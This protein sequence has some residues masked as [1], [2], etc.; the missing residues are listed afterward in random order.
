MLSLNTRARFHAPRTPS[1][2]HAFSRSP[3][4]GVLIAFS[5]TAL[6]ACSDSTT[7]RDTTYD[8]PT[9]T[10]TASAVAVVGPGEGGV[11]VTPKAIVE[12]YFVADIKVR[13]RKAM[14]NTTY[15]VQRAPEIGRASASNGICERA[16]GLAP[17]SS[18]DTPAPSFVSFVPSGQTTP[19]TLT[20]TAVG[21]GSVD[22]EFRAP[23]I[24]AGT[25]FDVMFR[26]INDASAPTAIVLSQCFT[27]T[28]L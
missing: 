6:S 2:A 19:V 12:G 1:G 22:F 7:P 18:A 27:V 11:S 25:K 10:H 16:L 3:H 4:R 21:D 9:G 24:P 17:W 15:I 20:T 8:N 23:M 26:L 14:P 13:L 28:V 5:L